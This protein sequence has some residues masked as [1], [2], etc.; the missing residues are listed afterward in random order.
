MDDILI[1]HATVITVD[2]SNRILRDAAIAIRGREIVALCSTRGLLCTRLHIRC[3]GRRMGRLISG[4]KKGLSPETAHRYG[5]K[6][7]LRRISSWNR[8]STP[9]LRGPISERIPGKPI[10]PVCAEWEHTGDF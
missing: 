3:A 2:S 4:G 7:V 5:E 6:P 1:T 8:W 9:G 10:E